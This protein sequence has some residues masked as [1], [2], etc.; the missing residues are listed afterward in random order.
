MERRTP[1]YVVCSARP[2]LGK[3]LVARLL[4][5]FL[6]ANDRPVM[7]F[8]V[9]PDEF[10]FAEFL[11]GHAAIAN[12]ADTRGQIA[13]FDNLIVSD[14][15]AKVIDLG[16]VSFERF[17]KLMQDLAFGLEAHDRAIEPVIV[18]LAD[19][20]R[21]SIQ[22][23]ANLM[24]RFPDLTLVPVLNEG[25][26]RVQQGQIS[27]GAFRPQRA[28]NVPVRIPHLPPFLR[29]VVDKPGFSFSA[30]MRR[31][32][33]TETHLHTWIKKAFLE[34]R[35]LELR[36]LLEQLKSNLQFQP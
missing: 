28:G 23:Y 24:A 26:W 7:G 8:D 22:G 19:P 21:R 6:I 17:F 30:F 31:P 36:L 16:T 13:L 33:E 27:P 12:L 14:A 5:E 15:V 4:T 25:I 10:T 18:F 11:P 9:N 32:A 2:R 29:G 3:T 1:V 20:D 35:E 34:F